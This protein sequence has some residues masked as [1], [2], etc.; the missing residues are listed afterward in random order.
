MCRQIKYRTK[1][2][3][4]TDLWNRFWILELCSKM[5]EDMGPTRH[6]IALEKDF[7]KV[8]LYA[9]EAIGCLRDGKDNAFMLGNYPMKHKNANN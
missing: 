7:R 1:Y 5:E 8:K 2:Q 9:L 4:K 6:K 3:T